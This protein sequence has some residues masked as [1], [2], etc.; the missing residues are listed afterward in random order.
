MKIPFSV[1]CCILLLSQP[2]KGIDPSGSEVVNLGYRADN[3][4]PL[5]L[6]LDSAVAHSVKLKVHDA[7]MEIQRSLIKEVK[8][9][10]TSHFYFDA[11]GRYGDQNNYNIEQITDNVSRVA[12]HQLSYAGG[13]SLKIPLSSFTLRKIR[14]QKAE[15][16]LLQLSYDKKTAEQQVRE[17]VIGSYNRLLLA[18]NLMELTSKS[19]HAAQV[20]VMMA[21][22]EYADGHIPVSELG[23]LQGILMDTQEAFQKAKASY[24][25]EAMLLQEI[26]GVAIKNRSVE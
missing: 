22:K 24:A 26:T 19:V 9:E 2:T 5:S 20:Q 3:L 15:A 23:R 11:F 10:W 4:P 17:L 16:R 14:I 18:I 1:F 12:S 7:G 8:R 13:L 6:L 21:E 25:L